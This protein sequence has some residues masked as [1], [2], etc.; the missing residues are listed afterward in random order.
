MQLAHRRYI[1]TGA[2][3]GIGRAVA[4]VFVEEGARVAMVDRAFANDP[5]APTDAC[6]AFACDVSSR[7][8]VEQTFAEAVAWLGGLDGLVNAAGV[9]R[10]SAAEDID[11]DLWEAVVG[12]NLRGTFLTNQ[13]AF[14][15]LCAAGG[16]RIMNFGSDA[17]TAPSPYGAHYAA[18]KGGVISW[19]RSIAHEWGHHGITANTIMPTIQTPMAAEYYSRLSASA[20]QDFDE[21]MLT[22]IPIGGKLGDARED[23]APVLVFLA[24]DASHFMT[25]QLICISGGFG[26][27]R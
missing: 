20:Q 19:T 24:T 1:V 22:R 11:D 10:R 25:G 4:E 9:E 18:S 26:T 27:T 13:A 15:H 7:A 5:V 17:G 2:A 3:R 16:G 8:D 21:R 6:A 14:P 23:L 12:V